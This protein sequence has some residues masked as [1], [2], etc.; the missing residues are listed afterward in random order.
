MI[1]ITYPPLFYLIG[2]SPSLCGWGSAGVT[3]FYKWADRGQL[4]APRQGADPLTLAKRFL[5]SLA[6]GFPSESLDPRA[7]LVSGS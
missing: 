6:H 2:P 1:I 4:P 3:P 5:P 7:R